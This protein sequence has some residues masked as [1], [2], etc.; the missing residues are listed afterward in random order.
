MYSLTYNLS[1]VSN[2]NSSQRY[3]NKKENAISSSIFD[4]LIEIIITRRLRPSTSSL[5]ST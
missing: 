1:L 4:S 3:T 2:N 5:F